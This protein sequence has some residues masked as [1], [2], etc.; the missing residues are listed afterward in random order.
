MNFTFD[1]VYQDATFGPVSVTLPATI[2]CEAS[3]AGPD[4]NDAEPESSTI[5]GSVDGGHDA[6]LDATPEAGPDADAASRLCGCGCGASVDCTTG[7]FVNCGSCV[8]PATCGG[9]G[10]Y[11]QCGTG[12]TCTPLTCASFG[13]QSCGTLYSSDG[14]GGS[15]SCCP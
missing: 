2:A 11:N 12:S 13:M 9:G 15:I 10:T 7:L 6:D 4:A 5:D 8:P 1:L 14:C 3:D